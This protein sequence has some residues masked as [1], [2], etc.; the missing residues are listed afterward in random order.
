M[1]PAA[2]DENDWT[3]DSVFAKYDIIVEPQNQAAYAAAYAD[4][5]QKFPRTWTCDPMAWVP[6]TMGEML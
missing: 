6:F 4:M 1:G 3:Q 2:I 5:M